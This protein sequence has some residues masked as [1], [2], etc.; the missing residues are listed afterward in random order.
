[1]SVFSFIYGKKNA[2]IGGITVDAAVREVHDTECDITDYPVEADTDKTDHVQMR[3]ESL[4][5]EGVIT[6]TP[7]T[8]SVIN[9]ATGLVETAMSYLGKSSR[10][11]DAYDKLCELQKKREPFQVVTGLKV[12]NNMI[13]KNLHVPRTAQTGNAIHFTARL[14]QILVAKADELS[15]MSLVKKLGTKNLGKK[16]SNIVPTESPIA[17]GATG[18]T[19]ETQQTRGASYLFNAYESLRGIF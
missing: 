5:I 10:S 18:V 11:K 14:R 15:G 8:L 13:L 9:A 7:V 19:S 4:M 16:V 12:Y 2:S 1:M 17:T 6:D 3:P